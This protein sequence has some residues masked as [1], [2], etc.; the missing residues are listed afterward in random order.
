MNHFKYALMAVAISGFGS[1]Q[2]STLEQFIE[3]KN[4][5]A[6]IEFDIEVAKKQRELKELNANGTE[7]SAPTM[8][9]AQIQ[10]FGERPPEPPTETDESISV[11]ETKASEAEKLKEQEREQEIAAL[12]NAR[13]VE[14]YQATTGPK[15]F[16]AIIS[17]G[18][19]LHEIWRGQRISQWEVGGVDLKSVVL[20]NDVLNA[21]RIV[22]YVR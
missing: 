13:L 8:P 11:L 2:A 21:R 18:N 12:R 6:D 5:I 15:R 1:T 7:P 10:Y 17:A 16:V 4:K 14:V 9:D 3:R 22:R 19:E 20:R